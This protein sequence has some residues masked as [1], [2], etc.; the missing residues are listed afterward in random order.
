[1]KLNEFKK[2]QSENKKKKESAEVLALVKVKP[3]VEV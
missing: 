2:Y 3:V 1:M